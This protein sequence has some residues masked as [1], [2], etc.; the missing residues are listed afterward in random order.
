MQIG[1]VPLGHARLMGGDLED[2]RLKRALA[3]KLHRRNADAFLEDRGGVGGQAAWH[4]A[5]DIGHVAEHCRPGDESPVSIDRRDHQLIVVVADG[6]LAGI[7]I[8]EE[9]H[10]AIFDF[11]VELAKEP[12]DE[13]AELTHHHSPLTVGDHGEGVALFADPR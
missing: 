5:A 3:V 7:G 9:D 1:L 8:V 4:L 11:A 12:V 6:A 2:V 10:V 13:G